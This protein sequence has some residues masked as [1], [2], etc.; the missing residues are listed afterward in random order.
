VGGLAAAGVTIA[1]DRTAA[2]AVMAAT[3]AGYS[4]A[5]GVHVFKTMQGFDGVGEDVI[6]SVRVKNFRDEKRVAEIFQSHGAAQ[7]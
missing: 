5:S 4:A 2:A 6:L 3:L 7:I 1:R